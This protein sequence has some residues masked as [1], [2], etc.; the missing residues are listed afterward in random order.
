MECDRQQGRERRLGL[1]GYVGEGKEWGMD[2]IYGQ[3]RTERASGHF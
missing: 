1:T 2:G 3:G